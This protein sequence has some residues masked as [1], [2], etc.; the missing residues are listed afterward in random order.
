MEVS[1]RGGGNRLSEVLK[2]ASGV[3]LITGAVKA[4]I[5]E[6]IVGIN[7]DP[8][9]D[10]AWAEVIVHSETDGLFDKIEMSEGFEENFVVEKQL[11]VKE[12]DEIHSFTGANF[13]IGSLIL[14]FENQQQLAQYMKEIDKHVKVITR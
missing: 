7:G 3:D 5:G 9:Y 6:E 4:A 10:G 13:A 11:W 2:L 8:V 1:P 14:R 12:G